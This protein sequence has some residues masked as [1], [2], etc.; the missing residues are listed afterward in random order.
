MEEHFDIPG[1][2]IELNSV[3]LE[4]RRVVVECVKLFL[5]KHEQVGSDNKT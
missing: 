5:H 4:R 2:I 3:A 1:E